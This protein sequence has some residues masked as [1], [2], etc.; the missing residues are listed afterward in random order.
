M[1]T[2]HTN[3]V[4]ELRSAVEDLIDGGALSYD[5]GNTRQLVRNVQKWVAKTAHTAAHEAPVGIYIYDPDANAF[6]PADEEEA[7]DA[8]GELRPGYTYLYKQS[9][10]LAS[11]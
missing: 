10:E 7:K 8:K 5:V 1:N 2:Q 4:Q 3:P 9:K 6:V 11:A